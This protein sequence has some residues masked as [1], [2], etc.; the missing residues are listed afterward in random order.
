MKRHVTRF[1]LLS[2]DDKP[3]GSPCTKLLL[4]WWEGKW[5]SRLHLQRVYMLRFHHGVA[6][7]AATTSLMQISFRHLQPHMNHIEGCV[8][9]DSVSPLGQWGL[10]SLVVLTTIFGS[11]FLASSPSRWHYLCSW[12]SCAVPKIAATTYSDKWLALTFLTSGCLSTWTSVLIAYQCWP[13]NN[14]LLASI[15]K[16]GSGT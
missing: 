15:M 7:M 8:G 16:H 13:A 1:Q 3:G 11:L 10:V 14:V 4:L 9:V 6:R 5:T 12:H 2:P